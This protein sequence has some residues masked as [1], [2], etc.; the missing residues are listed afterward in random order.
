M[1]KTKTIANAQGPVAGM[2]VAEKNAYLLAKHTAFHP[3][4]S[5]NFTLNPTP[6][7]PI[8]VAGR[9]FATA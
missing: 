9:R 3:R 6:S 8:H 4:F 7:K 5:S 1:S 2:T